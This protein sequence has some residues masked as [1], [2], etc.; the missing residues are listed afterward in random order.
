MKRFYFDISCN[1]CQKNIRRNSGSQKYC[2][3]CSRKQRK[4]YAKQ[5]GIIN[6]DK[7]R[8]L[9][10]KYYDAHRSQ[11]IKSMRHY[12]HMDRNSIAKKRLADPV[13]YW[14]RDTLFRHKKYGYSVNLDVNYLIEFVRSSDNRCKICG[15]SLLWHGKN[16]KTVSNSPSLYRTDNEKILT[17]ENIMLLCHKCNRTKNNRSLTEFINYCRRVALRFGDINEQKI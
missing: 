10:K 16:G 3:I 7:I 14:A 11:A 6:E 8:C 15:C 9:R 5:Y 13:L 4:D 12:Y 1:I 2:Y 17:K